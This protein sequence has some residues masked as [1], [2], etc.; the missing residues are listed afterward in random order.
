MRIHLFLK[1]LEALR[2]CYVSAKPCFI[3]LF[4]AYYL[5]LRRHLVSIL[6][7]AIGGIITESF[8]EVLNH[9]ELLRK[10]REKRRGG[11]K[12]TP[13]NW[14]LP[15]KQRKFLYFLLLQ[16]ARRH[17]YWN[18][19]IKNIREIPTSCNRSLGF[20]NFYCILGLLFFNIVQ[21]LV[22]LLGDMSQSFHLYIAHCG[23]NTLWCV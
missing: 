18:L 7:L 9:T 3:L 5:R 14:N 23:W 10:R 4:S 16:K 21:G 8:R 11:K 13:P 19:H 22:V 20:S 17:L 12:D 6:E 1:C 2:D 15:S